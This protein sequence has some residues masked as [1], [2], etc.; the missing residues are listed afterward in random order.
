M[1]RL[2]RRALA[3]GLLLVTWIPAAFL[4]GVDVFGAPAGGVQTTRSVLIFLA[5]VHVPVTLVLYM[6]RS[7]LRLVRESKA[8]YVYLPIALIVASGLIF[9]LGGA[10]VQAGALLLFLGWQAYHYG[11]QNIGVYAFASMA[12]DFR[13][14]QA[15][16]R[17]ID[18]A[19]ACGVLGTFK[20][21]ASDQVPGHLHG[22]FDLLF[23]A[24]FAVFLGAAL[25]GVY[26]YVKNRRDFPPG[27]AVFFFTLLLFFLPLFVSPGLDGAFFSYATAHG[28]QY[29]L[30]IA[31]LA[32]N[33]GA[34]DGRRGVSAG[35]VGL[36]AFLF[37][38]GL[39]GS[40]AADL[41]TID[42][43]ASYAIVGW[44]LDFAAGITVGA[45]I[46]HFVIDAGAWR[47]SSP[48]PRA[49]MAKRFGF[50]LGQVRPESPAPDAIL[51]PTIRETPLVR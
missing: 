41:K 9:T 44:T 28:V 38:F 22:V 2:K 48:S 15:E 3:L 12:L 16:R 36:A 30:L 31:V 27:K 51:S 47:L 46:A 37:L 4:L 21:L 40:R 29:I 14:R 8:R 19:T 39:A 7:F 25:F 13:P 6:D 45:T 24:G 23:R 43:V 32:L 1:T 26:L 50:L 34:T 17:V 33:L 18:V 11:R 20:V 10:L 49:Y 42:W 35:M 5:F